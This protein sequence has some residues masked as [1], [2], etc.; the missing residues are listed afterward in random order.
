MKL[1]FVWTSMANK[2]EVK[3]ALTGLGARILY[4]SNLEQLVQQVTSSVAYHCRT[5]QWKIITCS[6][7]H[8][9]WRN[10]TGE[11]DPKRMFL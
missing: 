4:F 1:F 3:A 5:K 8:S 9:C 6:Y 10:S 7:T 2:G 11:E